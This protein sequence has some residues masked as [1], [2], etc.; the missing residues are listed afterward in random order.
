MYFR[1]SLE[2]DASPEQAFRAFTDF[3]DRRLEVWSKTLGGTGDI[4]IIPRTDGGSTVH[5]ELDHRAEGEAGP[6]C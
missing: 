6:S 5:V 3:S 1:F 4:K 2:T